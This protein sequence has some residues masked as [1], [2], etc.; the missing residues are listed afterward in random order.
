[1]EILSSLFR[2]P[3][4]VQITF[5][6]PVHYLWIIN[7]ILIEICVDFR[8]TCKTMALIWAMASFRVYAR[9]WA[10]T[11][12]V[13]LLL[14]L[15]NNINEEIFYWS[16]WMLLNWLDNKDRSRVWG[17]IAHYS[18]ISNK[19]IHLSPHRFFEFFIQ[20]MSTTNISSLHII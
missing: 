7:L 19:K 18:V 9:D 17:A 20:E 1:M 15:Q 16:T 14:I 3:F 2:Y 8:F 5:I 12:C 6:W 13:L 4:T 10:C 11:V